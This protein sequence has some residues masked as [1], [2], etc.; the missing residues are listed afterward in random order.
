MYHIYIC[1]DT[2]TSDNASR[3][4]HPGGN[5]N[6]Q[7][8]NTTTTRTTGNRSIRNSRQTL[9]ALTVRKIN[10]VVIL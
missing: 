2:S 6:I 3:R 10:K 1:I 9:D 5:H 8:S 4:T 7:E